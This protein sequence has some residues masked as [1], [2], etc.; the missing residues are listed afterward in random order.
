MI[1][2]RERKIVANVKHT[3]AAISFCMLILIF[4]CIYC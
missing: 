4:G 2:K 3:L 1:D